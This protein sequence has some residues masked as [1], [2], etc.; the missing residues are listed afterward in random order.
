[1]T[2]TVEQ[3]LDIDGIVV[4]KIPA[5]STSLLTYWENKDAD[6]KLPD[7]E[8]IV[9]RDGRKYIQRVTTNAL[10]GYAV[11]MK[12]DQYARV[13]F[14]KKYDGFGPTIVAAYD[15]YMKKHGG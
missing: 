4:R 15:D 7:N 12:K 3:I 14:N 11:T 9:V 2:M 6:R 1:M 5:T 13:H 10:V 8:T